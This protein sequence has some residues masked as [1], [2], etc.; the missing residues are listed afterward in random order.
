VLS[1]NSTSSATSGRASCAT[2]DRL[3]AGLWPRL[4]ALGRLATYTANLR[5]AVRPRHAARTVSSGAEAVRLN[6]VEAKGPAARRRPAGSSHALGPHADEATARRP[7]S[8][9]GSP[10]GDRAADPA[11]ERRRGVRADS[12]TRRRCARPS[13]A[14]ERGRGV[15]GAEFRASPSSRWQARP[16][17]GARRQCDPSSARAAVRPGGVFVEVLHDVA[18]ARGAA[19]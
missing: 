2:R 14:P 4:Q 11:Q 10:R 1:R 19:A 5:R 13:P 6:E 7:S 12:A 3:P 9:I 16:G 17:A 18:A 8:A 15:P